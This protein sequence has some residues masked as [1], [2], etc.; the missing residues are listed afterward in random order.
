M[1]TRDH[2]IRPKLV[3]DPAFK[4][5]ITPQ[6]VF[7]E[8]KEYFNHTNDEGTPIRFLNNL[9][10]RPD[11]DL[12]RMHFVQEN[13]Y[14]WETMVSTA[15]YQLSQNEHSPS[16]IV[17]EP[18]GRV[19]TR[20]T[21]PELNMTYGCQM[22]ADSPKNLTSIIYGFLRGAARLTDKSWGA[23]IY[24]AVD[25]TDSFWFLTHAYDL[26]ARHFFFWDTYRQACVPFNECLALAKNLRQ[27]AEN[28]PNRDLGKLKKAAE[29]AI[30]LPPG[31]NLG[32]V[33]LGKGS[34]W[35]VGELNLE[36]RNRKGVKYRVVMNN[37]FT[38]IERCLRLG[39]AFDL[40]WDLP[41]MS[42]PDYREVVRIRED[43]KVAIIKGARRTVLERARTPQR[44]EGMPPQL[45]VQ[46]SA[47]EGESPL[48][49]SARATVVETG[50]PVFY[51]FGA[52][53]EGVY[54]D[55]KVAWEI[56][57]PGEEDYRYLI[58]ARRK[59]IVREKDGVAE[60]EIRFKL[61]RPGNY[62]LKAGTVDIAGRS[63]I[64]WTSFVVTE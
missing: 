23:S 26:G 38:E 53:S 50:A 43:G 55:A 36:R 1:R 49:I 42:L 4:K 8:F 41:E 39:V 10:Q 15:A 63:T 14:S 58:P 37:F 54:H 46:L 13:L 34:L 6:I 61:V 64:T 17:F 11:V 31:Y 44:P 29:V 35:G 28:F 40:L 51:T 27:H 25:R 52:D 47:V 56:Y 20:R 30:L 45:T 9:A 19:G 16:S 2:I 3:N 57:G 12:G 22:P 48:E 21:L 5:A 33:H 32:H 18:P 7:Q 60:V 24:G 62:R 59:P